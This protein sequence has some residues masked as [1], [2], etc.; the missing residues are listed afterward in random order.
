MRYGVD[1]ETALYDW[2]VLRRSVSASAHRLPATL[3]SGTVLSSALVELPD[4]YYFAMPD[5]KLIRVPI[6]IPALPHVHVVRTGGYTTDL[7]LEENNVDFDVYAEDESEAMTIATWLCGWVRELPQENFELTCYTSEITTL[8]YGN[9]DPRHP[10]L[11]RVTFKAL[12]RIRT[13]E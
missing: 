6:Q 4:G 3:G 11:G 8:P 2:L 10:T 5:D 12:I 7:V 1:I 9:P 13:K